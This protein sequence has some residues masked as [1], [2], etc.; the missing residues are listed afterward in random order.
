MK[1]VTSNGELDLPVDFS[2]ELEYNNPFFSDEG[3]ASVPAT[4]PATPNNLRVLD[5]IHRVDRANRFM[6]SVPATLM[7]GTIQK[8]GQLIID[9]L[10]M[11]DGISVS[12]AV[13]NSDL[14]SQY[15]NKSLK[16][17]FASKVRDDWNQDIAALANYL[18]GIRFNHSTDD[19]TIFPVAVAPYEENDA[20]IY[21]YN[22]EGTDALIWEARAVRENGVLISVTDGYGVSPFLY[23]YKLVDLLFRELGYTITYNCLDRDPYRDIVV[24]N[25]CSDTIVKGV[26]H[27]SDLVPSCT[28]S[29]FI[30]FLFK[31]FGIHIIVNSTSKTI[32]VVML[33]DLLTSAPT[34]DISSKVVDDLDVIIADTSRV[35]LSSETSIEG[36]APAAETFD[37]LIERYGYYIEVTEQ[38]YEDICNNNNPAYRDCLIMRQETGEF[39]ELGRRIGTDEIVPKFIGTNYFKYD[40][41]NASNSEALNSPDVMPAIIYNGIPYLFIGDRLHRN[42]TYNN[43]DNSSE[44]SIMIAWKTMLVIGNRYVTFG[45]IQKHFDGHKLKDFSLTTYDMYEY[46][47]SYYNELLRNN[48]VT[49]R[50]NVLYDII[51]ISS[52]DMAKI[53]SYRG[54]KILPLKNV[55][56]ISDNLKN[57]I[58]EFILIKDFYNSEKDVKILPDT[59]Q[60]YKWIEDFQFNETDIEL[61]KSKF[62]YIY[63][64][65]YAGNL[66]DMIAYYEGFT[67]KIKSKIDDETNIGVPKSEGEYSVSVRVDC[68][69]NPKAKIYFYTDGVVG[70]EIDVK[71]PSLH[72]F[73]YCDI[74]YK[75]VPV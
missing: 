5:N 9:T 26:I 13:E 63:Q 2:F 71:P 18:L 4:I 14:Y 28:M 19:F 55:F 32:E 45:T 48:K 57:H 50:G 34:M 1:L 73:S 49:L 59:N 35:I 25:N 41:N 68:E 54:Q 53:K 56:E 64:G 52:L 12:L 72:V 22:N 70:D 27:Y 62:P 7:A 43:S 30:D 46:F 21:Q 33:Q 10:S 37:K 66:Y 51:D 3:D 39:Y 20:K 42:T 61:L 40:R 74:R 44:Q 8:H 24:L 29:E 58:S 36:T 47:W 6:K 23:L 38:E 67:Y 11:K 31:K 15:K 65:L 16:E 69:L 17:I 75:S 60:K